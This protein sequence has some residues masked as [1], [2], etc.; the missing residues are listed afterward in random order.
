M[1]T[2]YKCQDFIDGGVDNTNYDKFCYKSKV[3]SQHFC[4][5]Q[6]GYADIECNDL[7]EGIQ[8]VFGDSTI[9]SPMRFNEKGEKNAKNYHSNHLKPLAWSL[10]Y[11]NYKINRKIS[12][13]GCDQVSLD[14]CR[15]IKIVKDG[16]FMAKRTELP[17][18]V[19]FWGSF[20]SMYVT[21]TTVDIG[22]SS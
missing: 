2:G 13:N 20:S 22:E 12:G 19:S 21:A 15:G 6:A 18:N 5:G 1:F 11:S 8:L 17:I 3:D 4:I 10:R 16:G 9:S 14:T 7:S